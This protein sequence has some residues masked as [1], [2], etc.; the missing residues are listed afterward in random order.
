MAAV[1]LWGLLLAASLPAASTV[2]Y[3]NPAALAGGVRELSHA[4]QSGHSPRVPDVWR[5]KTGDGT[6]SISSAPVKRLLAKDPAG[7][8]TWL[9]HLAQQLNQYN[10]PGLRA[11]PRTVLNRI[12]ARPEF[13]GNGPPSAWERFRQRLFAWI[14]RWLRRL[15]EAFGGHATGAWVVFWL[16]LIGAAGL[17]TF[18]IIQRTRNLAGLQLSGN[19]QELPVRTWDEWTAAAQAA[20][21]TGDL[22]TAVQCAYWAGVTRLQ[23][24]GVLPPDRTRTPREYLRALAAGSSATPFRALAQTLERCWYACLPATPEDFSRCLQSLEALGCKVN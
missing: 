17:L 22:R 14:A 6:F 23:V 19:R 9:N 3:P 15:F 5:V 10:S 16:V 12:L 7:A 18:W 2:E 4:L 24:Q 20:A 11:D 21:Q 13:A 8:Q 1:L